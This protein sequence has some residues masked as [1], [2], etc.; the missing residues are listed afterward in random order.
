MTELST[1]TGDAYSPIAL[2]SI[3]DVIY[4]AL[5]LDISRGVYEAGP[6]NIRKLADRFGVSPMPVREALRRLEAEGL[7]SFR[8]GR[9]VM[10]NALEL[11]DLEE[12]F[13]IRLTLEELAVRAATPRLAEMP[14]TLEELDALV[15]RMDEQV[16]DYDA[17]RETNRAFHTLLYRAA[18]MPRLVAIIDSVTVAADPYFRPYGV[19]RDL[20]TAQK[21]HRAI[22]KVVAAG[23]VEGAAAALRDHLR[24]AFDI[25]Q[26][27]PP[28]T[29]DHN[30]PSTD[31][32]R[33]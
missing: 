18:G 5:R 1:N 27:P 14:E 33:P 7:V 21:Q 22:V 31:Q 4:E 6:L 15:D 19:K 11:R 10:V 20:G 13:A 24:V 28:A 32:R 25:V 29:T 16:D 2:P 17:W 3:P 26:K 8:S 12:I 30:S 23:D 9:S